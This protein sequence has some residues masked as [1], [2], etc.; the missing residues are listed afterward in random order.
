MTAANIG[1][2]PAPD[3][4]DPEL[5][6]RIVA[7]RRVPAVDPRVARRD[8]PRDER[9]PARHDRADAAR[10]A[11]PRSV[12]G[13]QAP[14]RRVGR[15]L[16]SSSLHCRRRRGD[17]RRSGSV[18]S[19]CRSSLAN[20]GRRSLAGARRG[21]ARRTSSGRRSAA[22]S[23]LRSARSSARS[24]GCSSLEPIC[25]VLLGSSLR[26]PRRRRGVLARRLA[27]RD[28][29]LG[30]R[31]PLVGSLACVV[32]L[33]WAALYRSDLAFVRTNRRDVT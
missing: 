31:G 4:L 1:G 19:T 26:R 25:W 22:R 7:R 3:R 11:A 8:H 18:S 27:R 29:R 13:G 32:A 28:G 2:S 23:T 16:R 9:V 30:G 12:R 24:C 17:G 33:G 6:F 14:D 5:Q 15:G 21:R 10:D 20:G